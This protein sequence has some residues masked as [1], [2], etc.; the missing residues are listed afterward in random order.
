MVLVQPTRLTIWL[1]VGLW[2]SRRLFGLESSQLVTLSG[3]GSPAQLHAPRG[4]G[5]FQYHF[6]DFG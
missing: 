4:S 5:V 1:A 6:A 3:Y 2:K